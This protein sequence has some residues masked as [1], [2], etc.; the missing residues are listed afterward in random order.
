MVVVVVG[1]MPYVCC[2]ASAE[3][4]GAESAAVLVVPLGRHGPP[5][6]SCTTLGHLLQRRSAMDIKGVEGGGEESACARAAGGG[7]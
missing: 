3:G 4:G 5:P 7:Q 2:I 6:H 1:L